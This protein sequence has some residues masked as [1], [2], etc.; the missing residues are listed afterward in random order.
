M[1]Y[2]FST[3]TAELYCRRNAL[4]PSCIL[5]L[6]PVAHAADSLSFDLTNSPL[7]ERTH[8]GSDRWQHFLVNESAVSGV[9]STHRVCL[10][11]TFMT[12][13]R[14]LNDELAP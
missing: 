6:R 1:N 10:P 13:Y 5:C 9:S 3:G 4:L 2:K 11:P 7:E 12:S 8:V 14:H